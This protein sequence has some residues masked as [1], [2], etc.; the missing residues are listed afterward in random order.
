MLSHIRN[1]TIRSRETL[2]FAYKIIYMENIHIPESTLSETTLHILS[3]NVG[4]KRER[5]SA[6]SAQ[7]PSSGRAGRRFIRASARLADAKYP[8]FPS[9]I[10]KTRETRFTSG[11]ASDITASPT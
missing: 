10:Q 1:V 7:Y 11:P 4:E 9:I 8:S 3:L 5:R 2:K 6:E